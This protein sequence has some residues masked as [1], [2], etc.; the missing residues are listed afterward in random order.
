M[1]TRRP[2]IFSSLPRLEAVSPLPRL[3]ATPPVT[4]IWLVRTGRA[5][6]D[7]VPKSAPVVTAGGVGPPVHGVSEYQGLT[8]EK[9]EPPHGTLAACAQPAPT[10]TLRERS[11]DRS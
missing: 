2:R 8:C 11:G 3:D 1:L 6:C 4:K 10:P 7:G 9:D 5:A